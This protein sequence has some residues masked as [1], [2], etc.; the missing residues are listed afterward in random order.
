VRPETQEEHAQRKGFC[1][2]H[3]W[4]YEQ[5]AS[6]RGIC[7]AYPR[8][9][10]RMAQDF[11]AMAANGSANL[12]DS[13]V[14]PL[15]P[16]CK[17]RWDAE[18]RLVRAMVQKLSTKPEN[19]SMVSLCVPHLDLVLK[20]IEDESLRPRLLLREAAVMERTAEDMQRYAIKH[21]ALRRNLVSQEENDAP[22]LALQ[23][24]SGHRSVNAVFT[25]REI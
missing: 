25:I 13:L 2:L 18:D 3:T 15:C 21:D 12:G 5:V 11:R 22:L 9:L 7:T 16:A 6:P 10:K 4:H 20:Q 19:A 8:L 17:V 23:L 24:L 1:P 14:N